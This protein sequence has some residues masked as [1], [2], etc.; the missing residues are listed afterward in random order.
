MRVAVRWHHFVRRALLVLALLVP[1]LLPASA[2]ADTPRLLL[3]QERGSYS[4]DC[5]G[6]LMAMGSGFPEGAGVTLYFLKE[7][8]RG[9]NRDNIGGSLATVV[10]HEGRF[11]S[12]YV[13]LDFLLCARGGTTPTAY[14]DGTAIDIVAAV[15]IDFD[16]NFDT[17]VPKDGIALAHA[18]FVVDSRHPIPLTQRCF[19]ETFLC[20]TGQFYD[21]W[22]ATGGLARHGLPLT[23]ERIERLD[24]GREYTVQYFERSRLEY[25]PES[26]DARYRIALG[27]FGRAIYAANTGRESDPPALPRMGA[28]FFA[29]TGHNIEGR[30]LDYWQKEG[31]LEQFGYPL[32]EAITES[33]GGKPYTVQY[34]ERARFEYHPEN[35]APYDV[36]LGQFGRQLLA[37]NGR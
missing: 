28:T 1:A 13:G 26:A 36:L 18:T 14:P 3:S 23:A 20:T 6:R 11:V 17:A 31:G 16:Y 27:Q 2:S 21:Y 34:F 19:A 35:V 5:Q 25:H 10:A 12:G 33:I 15:G 37:E 4:P 22:L 24:D 29:E 9:L 7:P 32:T 30:F 8:G